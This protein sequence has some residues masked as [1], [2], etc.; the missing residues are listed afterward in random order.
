MRARAQRPQRRLLPRH[1]AQS[2]PA[3]R[4][5]GPGSALELARATQAGAEAIGRWC[6][7]QDVD[8]WY[9]RGGELRVS[10]TEAHDDVGLAS[11]RAADELGVGDRLVDLT[12]AQ[13]REHC[14]SPVFRRGVFAPDGATVPPGRAW[15]WV[16]RRG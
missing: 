13:V 6:E 10:T 14:D 15:R 3:A 2:R 11:A 12:P 9:R 16:S 1:L 8:A 7:E 5:L 4:P